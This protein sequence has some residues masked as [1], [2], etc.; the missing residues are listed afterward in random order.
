MRYFSILIS[1]LAF[2]SSCKDYVTSAK[3]EVK[4][5]T[6]EQFY[7][8]KNIGGGV[9]N[10][11]ETK[12]AVNNNETGIYNVYEINLADTS[13]KPVTKSAKESLFVNDYVA[14][15]DNII[16]SADQ[17]G[18]ENSHLYLL[19]PGDSAKDLTPGMKEKTSFF[20]W[21]KPRTTL[22]YTSNKRDPKYFD[23]YKMDTATW[24]SNMIYKNDSG[25]N[26]DNISFNEQYFLLSKAIT[27]DANEM[28]LFNASSKQMKKISTDADA[29]Y[30][31][32]GFELNDS[33]FYFTTNEGKEFTY[34]MK[35]N[36]ASGQKEKV[37]E[38]NW[39]VAY[40]YLSENGKYRVIGINEDGRNK[41]F[42]FDHATGS[43]IKFP[44]IPDGDVQG[45]NISNSEK[46]MIL[47]VGSDKSP[48]NL[49]LYNFETQKLKQVTNTLNAEINS[50]DLAKSEVVR[51]KSFD[52]VDVPAIYY[53]PLAASK[54]KPV[55]AL[56]WVHGG[57]GGQSRVGYSQSAQY[58]LNHGYAILMVNNRGSSGYGKTFHA[59]DDRDHGDKDLMDCVYGKRWLAK[60]ENID[61]TKIGIYGGSY[62]GFM[63]LEGIIQY[64]N[65]FKI[66]VDLYG[67]ANWPRTLKSIPPYWESFRKALYRE[68]GDP[69]TADSVRLRNISPLFNTEK[70]KTPLLVLQ[71]TND[72]RVLQK[73]SDEI[74]AGAKKN[75]TPVEY[76]LFPDEGH[77]FVKKENQM[78]AAE[79]TL[80]FLDK[81]L[82][83]P[84]KPGLN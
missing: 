59:M 31:P 38:T 75:G 18:N 71:G 44:E 10:K 66:G 73:E 53:H 16:Y 83:N 43:P 65:E 82:K 76:V 26:V 32:T 8:T 50:D 24:T 9:F 54:D 68:M 49:W 20:G 72:P 61:S 80:K 5:Y 45:V 22:Y 48:N 63:S 35:Y 7:K 70:I 21:N 60:Q 25:Y 40:M 28:Y 4:Q 33:S 69:Y 15:T 14:G 41:V 77:G 11:D 67:V 42:L 13:M 81:Y 46:N 30:S 52:G 17:G 29:A 79:T 56:V 57:P 1:A 84:Q 64:P 36:I 12:I 19:H 6:I 74:V 51:F 3:K 55:P 34:L 78:K 62:G 58:F 27:T 39:D 2:L 23:L 37:F 47:T